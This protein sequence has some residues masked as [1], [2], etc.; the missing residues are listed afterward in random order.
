MSD[1]GKV[2]ET[3]PLDTLHAEAEAATTVHEGVSGYVRGA[4]D[5]L[6]G[7]FNANNWIV[8]RRFLEDMHSRADDTGKAIAANTSEAKPAE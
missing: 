1:G 2:T 7:L 5:H 4:V 3:K 8:A 6:L